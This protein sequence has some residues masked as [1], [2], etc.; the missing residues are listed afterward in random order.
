MFFSPN[1]KKNCVI[2]L[3]ASLIYSKTPSKQSQ[4]TFG[5]RRISLKDILGNA[6]KAEAQC[7]N[8]RKKGAKTPGR[9]S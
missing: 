7:N 9:I 4:H 2:Q 3:K 1:T 5:K 8:L 6:G